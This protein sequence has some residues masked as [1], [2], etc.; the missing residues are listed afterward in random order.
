MRAFDIGD[1]YVNINTP[2]DIA[3]AEAENAER[4]GVDRFGDD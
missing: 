2:A 4:F 1:G 3:M